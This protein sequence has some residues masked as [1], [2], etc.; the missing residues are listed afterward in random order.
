MLSKAKILQNSHAVS[1]RS[2]MK[3]NEILVEQQLEEGPIDFAKQVGAGIKGLAQGGLQGAKAGYQQQGAANKQQDLVRTVSGNAG[4]DWADMATNIRMSTGKPPT[5]DDAVA[6]FTQFSGTSPTVAPA[7]SNPAQINKWL[8]QQ[9]SGYMVKKGTA[10]QGS[11]TATAQPATTQQP[12]T[13]Q[14]PVQEPATAQQSTAQEPTTAQA[15]TQSQAKPAEE[16][17]PLPIPLDKLTA[18]ERGEL[19]RQL[20]ASMK[21]A[22]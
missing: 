16:P 10:Q 8:N 20:Q 3:I 19:R 21:M 4:K 1:G 12:A 7:G 14:T 6:W 2:T 15:P 5:A 22:A 17:I 9:V 18:E 11:G 13:A